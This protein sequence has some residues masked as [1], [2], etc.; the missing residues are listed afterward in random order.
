MKALTRRLRDFAK[1]YFRPALRHFYLIERIFPEEAALEGRDV[2]NLRVLVPA[3]Q[4]EIASVETDPFVR[5][6]KYYREGWFKRPNVF[7]CDIP[8]AYLYVESGMVCTRNWKV[9]GDFD[10]RLTYFK[11]FGKRRPRRVQRLSGVYSTIGY[12]M[13]ANP[14]HWMID[15]LPKMVSLARAEP[16]TPVTLIM[17]DSLGK[18]QRESLAAVLPPHFELRYV[19]GDT[20]LQLKRF[21]WPSLASGWCNGFL[22]PDYFEG[23][24]RP[25]FQRYGLPAVHKQKERLYI[26]RRDTW[27]RRVLNEKALLELIGAYGFKTVEI[28]QLSFREQV[29]LFHRADI[30]LGPHGAGFNLLFFCGKID[31]VVLHPNRVPQNHFH[32]LARG[33]GQNYHFVLHDRGEEDDFVADLPALKRVLEEELGLAAVGPAKEV[34]M[35]TEVGG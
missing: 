19:P 21:I 25:I 35:L 15:C 14:Y 22:P 16:D 26:T 33:L 4:V 34:D 1:R 11:Q 6:G 5:V 17:S 13:D 23:I 31:V 32:T 9:A 24:R 12:G 10:F 8:D 3:Q 7:V 27:R 20:W 29:E 2:E 28:D 18:M 30:V